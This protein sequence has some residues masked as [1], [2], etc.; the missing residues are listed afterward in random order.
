MLETD[1]SRAWA[2]DLS[3]CNEGRDLSQ[4]SFNTIY[5]N[6]HNSETTT[7]LDTFTDV[8][9]VETFNNSESDDNDGSE[10]ADGGRPISV[11]VNI[12]KNHPPKVKS[13]PVLICLK[14]RTQ[15]DYTES[16][17]NIA[18]FNC[19][20]LLPKLPCLQ[21]IFEVLDVAGSGPYA[22]SADQALKRLFFTS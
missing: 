16:K 12:R 22:K 10:N 3:H 2:N 8:E 5:D 15:D 21:H 1:P 7:N 13:T 14:V 18:L 20:S 9:S 19:R 11:L 6:T 17:P 4:N